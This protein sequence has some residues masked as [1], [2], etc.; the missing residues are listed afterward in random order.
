MANNIVSFL[1]RT[2]DTCEGSLSIGP[3]ETISVND[4]FGPYDAK[5]GMV[6]ANGIMGYGAG[7]TAAGLTCV[8][9]NAGLHV[10]AT[11]ERMKLP[12]LPKECELPVIWLGSDK[13]SSKDAKITNNF[14]T[15]RTIHWLVKGGQVSIWVTE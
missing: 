5:S 13:S 15:A 9:M 14:E 7:N 6:V 11:W 8:S 4:L 12:D 3:G 1:C 10:N 2:E